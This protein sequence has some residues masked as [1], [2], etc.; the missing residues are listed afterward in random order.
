MQKSGRPTAKITS[1]YYVTGHYLASLWFRNHPIDPGNTNARRQWRKTHHTG[2]QR[3]STSSQGNHFVELHRTIHVHIRNT[4]STAGSSNPSG[5]HNFPFGIILWS[6]NVEGG[7]SKWRPVKR[8]TCMMIYS[9]GYTIDR[10]YTTDAPHA[11]LQFT[12]IMLC[13]PWMLDAP[14]APLRFITLLPLVHQ[15]LVNQ[16]LVNQW[17]AHQWIPN[18]KPLNTIN[19][20]LNIDSS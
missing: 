16:W 18:C 6:V 7:T 9:F 20:T 5:Q 14:H 12:P 2:A 8:K 4:T 11:P 17:F 13:R 19:T 3:V 10:R 1:P 15:W